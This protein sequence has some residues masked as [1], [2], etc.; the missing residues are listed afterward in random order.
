MRAVWDIAGALVL[1]ATLVSGCYATTGTPPGPTCSQ[2]PSQ[3][4][5]FPPVH[6]EKKRK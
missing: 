3:P 5:C 1:V 2:D 6:D 4:G